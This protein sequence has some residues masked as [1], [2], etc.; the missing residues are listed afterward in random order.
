MSS[1]PVSSPASAVERG[2]TLVEML[3]AVVIVGI[4]AAVALPS[5]NDSIRKSR[6]SDAF[7]ALAAV[8]Q[9]QE[10][11]RG[12]NASYSGA[13]TTDLRLPAVTSSGYYGVALSDP[14]AAGYTATATAVSGKSQAAD[15]T[16]VRLRVRMAG[17]NIVYGSAAATGDFDESGSNRCWSR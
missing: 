15:G 12:G 10:R 6:R 16:C 3:I 1:R 14:S 7:A 9:A 17:G 4:L 8:Q 13:L 5:F 2:F 11:W